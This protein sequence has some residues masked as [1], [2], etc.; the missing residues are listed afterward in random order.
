ML[1]M[2]KRWPLAS[3]GS[4]TTP[5]SVKNMYEKTITIA[6]GNS[7]LGKLANIFCNLFRCMAFSFSH[8][9]PV[10]LVKTKDFASSEES[11]GFAALTLFTMNIKVKCPVSLRIFFPVKEFSHS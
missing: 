11:T 5:H 7:S 2:E 1:L 8:V 4:S 3:E 6:K 9:L 10:L